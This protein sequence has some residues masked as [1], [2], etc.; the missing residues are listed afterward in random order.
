MT[1]YEKSYIYNDRAVLNH[2]FKRIFIFKRSKYE[3][4]STLDC[5]I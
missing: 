4:I 1:I 3:K 2:N 5:I